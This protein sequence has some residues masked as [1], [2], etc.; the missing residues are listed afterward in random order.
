MYE[1]VATGLAAVFTAIVAG[2]LISAYK[3]VAQD[4]I[5]EYEEENDSES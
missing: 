5:S 4:D 1:I 3:L 2:V